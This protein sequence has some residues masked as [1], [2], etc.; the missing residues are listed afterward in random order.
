MKLIMKFGG[1]SVQ[2]AESVRR[3]VD[4]VYER[5]SRQ[6]RLAVVVSAR[7][8]VTDRL[9]ACA[10]SMVTSRDADEVADLVTYLTEGH[11]TTLK[12]VAPDFYPETSEI[13]IR[14][15]ENLRDFLHAVYHLRELT[16]RSRDYITSFGERLNAPLISAAF[17]QR[18]IP[19]MVLDGCE[20]G[21]LTTENHGDAIALPAGEARIRSRLEPVIEHS[22]PVITGFM[23]C[24]EKGVVTTLGRSGSDYSA[25]IVGAALD[26][27]EIWIW[28]DVD[29]IMTTDPRMVPE[30][31]VI[32]RISYIE[33]M[34]LS[35]FGA[36]V[37]HSRSIE[38]AMQKGIPVL[39]KN[40]N[41]PGYPGTVIDGGE[42]KDS[43]VVK[44]ITYIDKV[45]AVTITGAQMVGRPGV[46]RHIFSLLAEH[47]INV[48]MI[49]QGSS[50]ANI[51]LV[52]EANQVALAMEALSP[53]KERCVFRDITANEDVSAVAVV[54]S[55]MA[56]M[57]GTAGRTFSALGKAG[58]NVMMITQGSSEVNISFIVRQQDGPRA[59]KVLH[60]EF[61]L[62]NDEG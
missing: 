20:A 59:V 52:I 4:I 26:A 38:P 7:R 5:Y 46:A 39:V 50:E 62:M 16:V 43:R 21:I 1:T 33:V 10:E 51:T 13:I 31:R 15:I 3:A 6:D 9:I 11:L 34:E 47:Q 54:G 37:M 61:N 18:G 24:T 30:A 19:S 48:M 35:Y 56:G 42:K 14:R 49:S 41:N 32:P 58:I 8:G 53:L 27:D 22:V 29:G 25:T 60:D 17:R 57:A 36:K 40:A 2:N 28:T 55:G 45:A 12:E 44:A 23:G